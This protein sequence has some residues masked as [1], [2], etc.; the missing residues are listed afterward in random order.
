[1]AIYADKNLYKGVNPHLHSR[2]QRGTDDLINF[3]PFH[4]D[5]ITNL[6]QTLNRLLPHPYRAISEQT[7]QVTAHPGSKPTQPIPDVTIFN[8]APTRRDLGGL[9]A[10]APSVTWDAAVEETLFDDEPHELSAVLI[11]QKVD[12]QR[13]IPVA[14]IEL[15]SPSNKLGG[16]YYYAYL[17]RRRECLQSG[18]PLV[19]I[20]Y[21]H[22]SGSP[23]VGLPAYPNDPNSYAYHVIVSDPRYPPTVKSVWAY[24]FTVDAPI[25]TVIIPLAGDDTVTLALDEVYQYTFEAGK[26]GDEVDYLIPPERLATY[27]PADQAH[28]TARMTA[29]AAEYT[30]S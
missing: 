4:S 15:L 30:A 9:A 23:V 6:S 26:W 2:F 19:E 29:I 28:I 17:K 10:L 5:H 18:L 22:E 8:R 14:R 24:G 3:R 16:S 21:L 25:P 27:S 13:G 20:D 7:L 11:Y 12:M 1:M